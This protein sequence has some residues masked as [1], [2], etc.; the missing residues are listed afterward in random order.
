MF[1]RTALS[2][3]LAAALVAVFGLAAIPA[4]NAD[5]GDNSKMVRKGRFVWHAPTVT[6]EKATAQAPRAMKQTGVVYD[7]GSAGTYVRHGRTVTKAITP[8]ARPA[9]KKTDYEATRHRVLD[10][11]KHKHYLP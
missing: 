8:S 10:H 9:A 1:V 7:K 4:A 5:G 3:L 6:G 11:A 2:T